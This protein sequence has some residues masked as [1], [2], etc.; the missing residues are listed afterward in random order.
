L[1]R[2][3]YRPF[4]APPPSTNTSAAPSAEDIVRLN[5]SPVPFDV[6]MA[7]GRLAEQIDPAK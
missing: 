3:D 6:E 5:N 7:F 4:A 1:K 2:L